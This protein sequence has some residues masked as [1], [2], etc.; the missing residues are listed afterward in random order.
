M[1]YMNQFFAGKG[2]EDK[3]DLPA[4]SIDG[5]V[6]PGKRLQEK[7]EES[8]EI[9]VTAYCG[10]NYFSEHTDES[11]EAILKIAREYKV[12]LLVAGPAFNSGR[13]GFACAQV[14]HAASNSLGLHCISAMHPENPGIETYIQYKDRRVFALPAAKDVSGMEDALSRMAQFAQKI[15]TGST[16]GPAAEEGYIPRGIRVVDPVSN[17]GVERALEMLL[18]H[19]F[20]RPYVTEIPIEIPAKNPIASPVADL[21]HAHL[22]VVTEAGIVPEGNPDEFKTHHNTRWGKYSIERLSSMKE[23]RWEI[24]HGGW[25]SSFMAANPNFGVP[26][27]VLREINRDG[28][29][30]RLYPCFYSMCGLNGAISD[31]RRIGREIASDMKNEGIDCV[32]LVAT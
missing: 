1:H 15:V 2:G 26:L 29:F 4:G 24:K 10:D 32:L 11:L 8:A 13:H 20:S 27:D 18:S 22:A 31:M 23:G 6:G 7:L 9:V 16:I 5:V 21:A 30:N 19:H 28:S 25:G 12:D 14:C 3:A 17:S